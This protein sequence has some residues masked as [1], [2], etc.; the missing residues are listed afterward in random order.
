MLDVLV[1]IVFADDS[2]FL[3][4][5]DIRFYKFCDFERVVVRLEKNYQETVSC[6][7]VENYDTVLAGVIF[8]NRY[9][10]Q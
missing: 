4:F 1:D 3:D 10:F 6:G 7:R 9:L 2:L 8:E 5:V